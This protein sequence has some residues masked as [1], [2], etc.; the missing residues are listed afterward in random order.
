MIVGVLMIVAGW[1]FAFE[2]PFWWIVLSL[3]ALCWAEVLVVLPLFIIVEFPRVHKTLVMIFMTF[4]IFITILG[5]SFAIG[6]ALSKIFS[7][8]R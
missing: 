5:G 4:C 3:S 1:G 7:R 6:E 2:H 8:K